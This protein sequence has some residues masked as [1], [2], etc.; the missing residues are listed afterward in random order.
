MLHCHI[1]ES[2][3]LPT[4]KTGKKGKR[5]VPAWAWVVALFVSLLIIVL[6]GTPYAIEWYLKRWLTDNGAVEI[7]ID[8]VN[9]NPFLGRA[10][11]K[12]LRFTSGDAPQGADHIV[13]RVAWRDLFARQV[14]FKRVVIRHANI[15]VRRTETNRLFLAAVALGGAEAVEAAQDVEEASGWGVGLAGVE[16]ENVSVH[17]VDPL[18]D[19]DVSIPGFS[20]D[21]MTT[22]EPDRDS[23]LSGRIEIGDTFFELDGGFRPFAE[24]FRMQAAAKAGNVPLAAFRK[25]FPEWGLGALEGTIALD[26]ELGLAEEDNGEI[27][28][29]YEGRFDGVE[30]DVV[31]GG[32]SLDIDAINWDGRAEVAIRPD[33]VGAVTKGELSLEAVN[34]G[35]TVEGLTATAEG[36]SWVGD[37]SVRSSGAGLDVELT[38][39][40]SANGARLDSEPLGSSAPD[41]SRA[42]LD[43][44]EFNAQSFSLSSGEQRAELAHSGSFLVSGVEIQ[45]GAASV[46][47][48]SVDWEGD[49]GYRTAGDETTVSA[50]GD[51]GLASLALEDGSGLSTGLEAMTWTGE[52]RALS[53]A[54]WRLDVDGSTR[55]DELEVIKSGAELLRVAGISAAFDPTS[56]SGAVIVRPLELDSIAA[57]KRPGRGGDQEPGHVVEIGNVNV[58]AL[59]AGPDHLDIGDVGID[60]M[61]VWLSI[62]PEGKLELR[63]LLATIFQQPAGETPRESGEEEDAAG[64]SDSPG[65]RYSVA[66]VATVNPVTI[67]YRDDTVK[68]RVSLSFTPM[69]FTVG[70]ID[71]YEPEKDTDVKLT[72]QLGRYGKLGYEGTLRPLAAKLTAVGTGT[73]DALDITAFDGYSRRNNG[74]RVDS[75]TVS[76]DVTVDIREDQVDSLA[77][78]VIRELDVVRIVP[79]E[80]DEMG[81]EL[82]MPL[83]VA[84]SLLKDKQDNINLDVPLE[85]DLSELSADFGHALRIVL[86]K[87]IMVGVRTAAT[88]FFAPLWPVL[89]AEKVVGAM[90]KLKFKAVEFLPGGTDMNVEGAAYLDELAGLVSERPEFSLKICGRAVTRD[91]A[92]MFPDAVGQP[93]GEEQLSVLKEMAVERQRGVKDGLIA[94]GI[95]AA[96]VVTC[97]P[98][99][100]RDDQGLPRVDIGI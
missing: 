75:G 8:D 91:R 98:D 83:D 77:K 36:L 93:L 89:A 94:R 41:A 86:N 47:V 29:V 53:G 32:Y 37:A 10:E 85:G 2:G 4:R 87:G 45:T 7:D 54:P 70:R 44:L 13:L 9:F 61:R 68:P 90:T 57:L 1:Q 11:L 99:P 66:S 52:A 79:E 12:S 76:A 40:F 5:R 22:W 69:S 64:H 49:S 34:G 15:S 58:S 43:R 42:V 33:G 46:V 97:A 80:Q 84:F 35:S 20:A 3:Y 63:D 21:R 60:G 30:T 50:A 92:V 14:M 55:L 48:G 78:F 88:T 51:L 28:V 26:G 73:V 82:G 72:T 74:Y 56:D 24:N 71:S 16:L 19:Y 59:S 67:D 95:E 38:G 62:A 39:T 81:Q 25:A 23:R 17:Y 6:V 18:L 96:R 31:G 27:R 65:F 100:E